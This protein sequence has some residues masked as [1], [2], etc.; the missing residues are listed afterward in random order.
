MPPLGAD[1]IFLSLAFC[2]AAVNKNGANCTW[3]DVNLL[4][5]GIPASPKQRPERCGGDGF[6]FDYC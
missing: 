6:A 2:R 1:D 5:R 4:L 3:H